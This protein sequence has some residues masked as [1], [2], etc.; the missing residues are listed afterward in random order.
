[1]SSG[2]LPGAGSA[3]A[4][5]RSPLDDP[6]R[7][8]L[9]LSGGGFRAT[10]FH[11]GVLT[12]LAELDLLRHLHMI[13]S[14]SGGSVL[15]AHYMLHLKLELERSVT[16]RL[17]RETYVGLV[18]RLREELERT[19]ARAPRNLLLANPLANLRMALLG[20]SRFRLSMSDRMAGAWQRLLFAEGTRRIAPGDARAIREGLRLPD[21]TIELP[22][23]AA[24]ND[25]QRY[26]ARADADCVPQLVLNAAT[27]NTASRFTFTFVEV[28]DEVLGYVRF[29]ERALITHYRRVLDAWQPADDVEQAA[30]LAWNRATTQPPEVDAAGRLATSVSAGFE[31][32]EFVAEHL[33]WFRAATLEQEERG[34]SPGRPPAEIARMRKARPGGTLAFRD[35]PRST[36]VRHLETR[37]EHAL[38]LLEAP[39]SVLRTAKVAAWYLLHEKSW[40]P[41]AVAAA[42]EASGAPLRRGGFTHAE[43]RQ[44]FWAAVRDVDQAMVEEI[45]PQAVAARPAARDEWHWY[46]LVLEL[47]YLRVAR[48]LEVEHPEDIRLPTAVQASA[49]FP[50]VFGAL[51]FFGLYDRARIPVVQLSDGGLNDNNGIEALLEGRCTHIIASEAGPRPGIHSPVRMNRLGLLQQVIVNQLPIVRRLLMRTLREEQRVHA[52]LDSIGAAG[53]E[54]SDAMRDLWRRYPVQAV[55]FFDM[56]TNLSNGIDELTEPRP[57]PPH[58]L[59]R[60]IALLR[61]DLDGFTALEQDALLYQGYQYADRFVR[62]YL[63]ADLAARVGLPGAPP[64]AVAPAPLPRSDAEWA[65][66]RRVLR[67]GSSLFR[68]AWAIGGI[69]RGLWLVTALLGLVALAGLGIVIEGG[70]SAL[71]ALFA[72][73]GSVTRG[74]LAVVTWIVALLL[75][76]VPA[77]DV[78]GLWVW[79][80]GRL[81]ARAARRR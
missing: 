30:S 26:N 37:W 32:R 2:T 70:R 29:D 33:A 34:T 40:A 9:A 56:D 50:P 35:G 39:F 54:P 21:L 42:T 15:A 74:V 10:L 4:R 1:M 58:P 19:L 47:Y 76:L 18:R 28:G 55:A 79:L 64:P 38:R 62:R 11:L 27:L 59:A 14:V 72:E 45:H 43:H 41:A 25:I 65:H 24:T 52:A 69:E 68:R 53:R 49:N 48:N 78:F 66:A 67:A 31:R 12:R 17:P 44:R 77:M 60:D 46:E 73:R 51:R 3:I 75:W 80:D 22:A 57:L 36:A 61:T 20:A 16:G 63:Y 7:L 23:L 71:L 6:P 13:S 81:A 5:D 8:G